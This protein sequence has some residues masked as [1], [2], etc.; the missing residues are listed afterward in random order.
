MSLDIEGKDKNRFLK[1]QTVTLTVLVLCLAMVLT[2]AGEGLLRLLGYEPGFAGIKRVDKLEVY[3]SFF[4]DGEGVFKA[5]REH[6]FTEHDA[7]IRIN[8]DGFRGREFEYVET[9]VS[10]ILFL[11]DSFT[12]G[13]SAEPITGSFVDIVERRGFITYNTGIGGADPAQYTFLAE[14]Y[15][16]VLKPDIVAVMFYMS[17]DMLKVCSPM[18]PNKNLFYTTNAGWILGYAED[19]SL[20]FGSAQEAYS[21]Y[22]LG[23]RHLRARIGNIFYKS[24]IGTRLW[25]T[26]LYVSGVIRDMLKETGTPD[27]GDQGSVDED[28]DAYCFVKS[29]SRI[30]NACGKHDA[31]FMLFLIPVGPALGTPEKSIDN[32]LHYFQKFKPR[33]PDMLTVDDYMELPNDHFNNKGH[34]KYADFIIEEINKLKL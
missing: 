14:K 28:P 19:Y 22:V 7:E 12:W 34:K 4:T 33:V 25:N 3:D 11:G 16:P 10:R 23:E 8:S 27:E 13:A 24:V 26:L 17:N 6:D 30:R 9:D 1:H 29:L 31:E 20:H 21:Y 2:L 5:N 15:I 32:N 18:L